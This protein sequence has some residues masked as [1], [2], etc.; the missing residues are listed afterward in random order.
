MNL[1]FVK[2]QCSVC[3]VDGTPLVD[4]TFEFPAFDAE[5]P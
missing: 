1:T 4:N 2:E 5:N 3:V